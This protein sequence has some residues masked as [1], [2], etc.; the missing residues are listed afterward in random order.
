MQRALASGVKF[1]YGTDAGVF[2]H[3][4]NNKDCG[5]LV[6]MGMRP[7]DVLRSATRS[8]ADLIA[9]TDRGVL[10]TD[11]LA[12]IIAVDGNPTRQISVVSKPS[13]HARREK[14]GPGQVKLVN[15]SSPGKPRQR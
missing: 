1:T 3:A 15:F 6:S 14:A 13:F 8:A 2:P 11:K 10:A 12:D 7:I 9:T 4:E 5:L